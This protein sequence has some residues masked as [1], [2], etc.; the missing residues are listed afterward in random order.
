MLK[1]TIVGS[2]PQPDWLI[3]R[4]AL[5]SRV[6]PRV[7]A[8]ELWRVDPSLLAQAQDDA[9]ELAVRT[10]ERI[11]LD[12]LTD[13]EIRRESYSNHFATALE[14]LD[15]DNPGET[16]GRGGKTSLVPRVVGPISRPG[17]V[18]VR[19]VQFLKSLTKRS[20]KATVPGPFTLSQQTQDEHY[21]DGRALAL[22]FADVVNAEL[23]DL[24][25]AG[26]DVVQIDEPWLQS[27]PEAAREFA[28]EAVDRALAGIEA[29]TVLHVCY[30]YAALVKEKQGQYGFLTELND[31]VVDQISIEAAQPRLDLSVL[32][33]LSKKTII[34]GVLDLG[35]HTVETPEII[36]GRL[37]AALEYVEPERLM[38][39]PDCGM[40]YLPRAA[41]DGKLDAMV[42][43]AEIVRNEL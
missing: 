42:R 3:D 1:T 33:G 30:G 10:M 26:A 38:A 20:V 14:G 4:V 41:A 39:G 36:A 13:G 23:R 32:A 25:A 5:G 37:R 12:I 34:L 8:R 17:P 35:D 19:D 15:L 31:T 16:V 43:G 28:A 9:T 6:P 18:G 2:Y 27:R 24:V 40:K 29:T 7:R 11:G 22:A 21:H